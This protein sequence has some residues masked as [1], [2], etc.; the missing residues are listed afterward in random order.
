LYNLANKLKDA[1]I[2]VGEIRK[3]F[4]VDE[5]PTLPVSVSGKIDGETVD[6]VACYGNGYVITDDIG[7]V[8]KE[9]KTDDEVVDFLVGLN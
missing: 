7:T 4:D 3:T 9:L 1:G 6:A 2:A 5:D 8:L